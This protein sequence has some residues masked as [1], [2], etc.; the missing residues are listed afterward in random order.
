MRGKIHF[1]RAWVGILVFALMMVMG[2]GGCGSREIHGADRKSAAAGETGTETVIVREMEKVNAAGNE[3][4]ES[5][6]KESGE[7]A[8][9]ENSEGEG[10]ESGEGAG[11]ENSEG[12]GKESGEGEERENREDAV[13]E[14]GQKA[15]KGEAGSIEIAIDERLADM[16]LREKVLQMFMITPEALTGKERVTASGILTQQAVEKYPVGGIIYFSSNIENPEQLKAMLSNTMSYYEQFQAPVPFLAVDEEGGTV[17]RIGNHAD[18]HVEK[19]DDMCVVGARGNADEAEEIGRK[20]GAYL[21]ELGFNLDFAPVA[22]VLT[23]PENTVVARR[24]FGSDP[25]LVADM[26]LAAAK[27]LQSQ[28]I[29]AAMKHFPGHGSTAA[30]THQGYA[31]TD[32]TLEE[33]MASDLIPFREAA[34]QNIPFIM[35][36]HISV[37][38]ITGDNTPC[39]LSKYMITTVLREQ[40]GYRGIVI[41]DAMNMGAVA[42]QYSSGEAAVKAI[43]AGADVILMPED[44]QQALDSVLHAVESGAISETRIEESV[45]KILEI[46]MIYL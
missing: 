3:S 41:T 35:A 42:S 26:A 12:A 37:P 32:K 9:K 29:C 19:F 30:D 31:Y 36:A 34:L 14:A 21:S 33:L 2:I 40:L 44:F 11:K 6:G 28:G 38:S 5:A 23:N 24:S 22:D 39:S 45:R 46:K 25:E 8:G 16:S 18:F 7:S 1:K 17:A 4:S 27:G 13:K 15:A 43:K 10:K 20:I